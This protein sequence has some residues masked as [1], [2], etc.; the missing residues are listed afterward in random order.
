MDSFFGAMAIFIDHP[1]VAAP[2]GLLL[3]AVG[4][5]THRGLATTAGVMWLLYSL[6]E[7]AIKQRWTCRGDCNIRAD[8]LFIYPVLFIASV[9]AIVSLLMKRRLPGQ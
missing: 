6:W 4:R 3:I 8:L 1:L 2:I 5:W 7:F 9:A